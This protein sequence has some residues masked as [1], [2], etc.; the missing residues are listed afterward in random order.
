MRGR[1]KVGAPARRH[2]GWYASRMLLF[3]LPGWAFGSEPMPEHTL[4]HWSEVVP[5][6]RATVTDADFPAAA[7]EL[8]RDKVTCLVRV[9]VD[10][11]GVPERSESVECDPVLLPSTQSIVTRY[12]FHP[13]LGSDGMPIPFAFGL[14]I[15]F[16]DGA[17]H[18][19][20]WSPALLAAMDA[21]GGY[22]PIEPGKLVVRNEAPKKLRLVPNG[23]REHAVADRMCRLHVR[24][25]SEGQ[26]HDAIPVRC[27]ADLKAAA[28]GLVEG[29]RFKP[30]R[31]VPT[32][33]SFD[34]LVNYDGAVPVVSFEASEFAAN[35]E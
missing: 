7:S 23:A 16:G 5:K 1:R 28:V 30:T 33:A 11:D 15:E 18:M 26:V 3:Y 13:H 19:E 31:R 2:A 22:T 6:V 32:P 10:K 24:V 14:R 9:Y 27:A 4:L 34:A 35:T 20:T 12:R 8:P 17:T 29:Y 21:R 25:R